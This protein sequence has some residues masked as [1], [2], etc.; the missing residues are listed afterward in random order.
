[1]WYG[2]SVG[3][4]GWYRGSVADTGE[5][6][7]DKGSV[8]EAWSVPLCSIFLPYIVLKTYSSHVFGRPTFLQISRH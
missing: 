4:C 6:G 2:E 8:S 3:E 5:C 1:V 7:W